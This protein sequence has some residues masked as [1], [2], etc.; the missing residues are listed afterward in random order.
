MDGVILPLV[1]GAIGVGLVLEALR[2]LGVFKEKRRD[3]G[4]DD[5]DGFS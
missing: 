2:Y 3:Q 5:T 1:I 4:Y